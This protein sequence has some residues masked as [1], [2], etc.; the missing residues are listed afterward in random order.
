MDLQ[1]DSYTLRRNVLFAVGNENLVCVRG[2]VAMLQRDGH[3]PNRRFV[4]NSA[5]TSDEIKLD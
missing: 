4:E 5:V 1:P 2:S 3:T